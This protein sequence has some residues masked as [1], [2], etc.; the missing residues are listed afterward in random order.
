MHF[1][2]SLDCMHCHNSCLWVAIDVSIY[3][4]ATKP[5]YFSRINELSLLSCLLWRKSFWPWSFPSDA[6]PSRARK[7]GAFLTHGR[8]YRRM[9]LVYFVTPS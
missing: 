6:V 3:E 2:T 9:G 4:S 8:Q 1:H 5:K 7:L